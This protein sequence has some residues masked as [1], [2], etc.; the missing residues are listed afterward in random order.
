MDPLVN[1]FFLF[2][3]LSKCF[4]FNKQK[5]VY[6]TCFSQFCYSILCK[7]S[8]WPT[9]R[10]VSLFW[11]KWRM[12][13]KSSKHLSTSLQK[14]MRGKKHFDLFS[15]YQNICIIIVVQGHIIK[16][17]VLGQYGVYM[18]GHYSVYQIQRNEN[19]EQ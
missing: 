6:H 3:F 8:Q 7:S 13:K 14:Q 9:Q 10:S 15:K 18:Y 12:L 19:L 5:D 16:V 11:S 2:L 17:R 4:Y 1:I